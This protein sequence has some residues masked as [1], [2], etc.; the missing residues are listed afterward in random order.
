VRRIRLEVAARMLAS[1][2]LPLPQVARACGFSSAETLRQ[3]FVVR[4]Q[5]T[6]SLFRSTQSSAASRPATLPDR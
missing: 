3:A 1:T 4:Y 5:V 2:D 6:P